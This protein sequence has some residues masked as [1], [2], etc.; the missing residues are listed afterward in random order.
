MKKLIYIVS[1]AVLT[2]V[3]GCGDDFLDTQNRY[4]KDLET[5]YQNPQ[6]IDE[7]MAGIYNA[8]YT[9]DV[10]SQEGISA[11]LLSDMVLGGGGPDDRA[12]KYLDGFQ[13]PEEDT[14]HDLWVY[15][16]RGIYRAN[17]LIEKATE[18]DLSG[19]F[20]S[21]EEAQ[22]FK[23]QKLGE[24]YFMRAFYY[25]RMAKFFGGVPLI[26]TLDDPKDAA[27][28]SFTETF[29]QIASDLQKAIE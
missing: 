8:M 12:A 1:V 14:F 22:A 15:S 2:L 16:Y 17:T 7:A 9:P 11:N 13:D 5:F 3:A 18:A 20:T 23:N 28:S 29:S 26:L 19:D 10:F 4:A 27:R 6:D 24:A 25:F 21:E